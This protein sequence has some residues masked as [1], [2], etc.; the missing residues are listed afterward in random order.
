MQGSEASADAADVTQGLADAS[1]DLLSSLN[2]MLD[3]LHAP[4]A[5]SQAEESLTSLGT[6]MNEPAEA[7]AQPGISTSINGADVS[8]SVEAA[9]E[10]DQDHGE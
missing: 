8:K 4:G 5:V 9:D 1:E 10:L 6:A 2:S 3:S 7:L